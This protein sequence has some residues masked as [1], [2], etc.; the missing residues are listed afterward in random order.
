M[1]ISYAVLIVGGIT[2]KM[3]SPILE[4]GSVKEIMPLDMWYPYKLNNNFKFWISY[5]HQVIPGVLCCLT[6]SG[7]NT[8]YVG[9]IMQVLYQLKIFKTRFVHIK[10]QSEFVKS[11]TAAEE[12]STIEKKI[13]IARLIELENIYRYLA[14]QLIKL[15][16][17]SPNF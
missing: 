10:K 5:F 11:M 14:G 13:L 1:E 3:V 9:F 8:M 17:K 6:H 2:T 12:L 7:I 4:T 16:S 15:V